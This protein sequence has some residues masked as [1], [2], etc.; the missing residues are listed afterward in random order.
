MLITLKRSYLHLPLV[1]FF[2]ILQTFVPASFA[3]ESFDIII[4]DGRIVDGSG[5]PWYNADVGI[6]GERI[7]R[8][9]NLDSANATQTIDATGLTVTPGFIDPHTHALQGILMCPTLKVRCFRV[10]RR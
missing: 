2:S 6:V 5:N 9:G 4:K 1:A 3:Q 7:T 10:L 8:I